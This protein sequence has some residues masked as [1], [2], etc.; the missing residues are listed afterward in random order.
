MTKAAGGLKANPSSLKV[1]SVTYM[2]TFICQYLILTVDRSS[3][4]FS[5]SADCV[6]VIANPGTFVVKPR[7]GSTQPCGVYIAGLHNETITVDFGLVDV[8]CDDDGVVA[9]RILLAMLDHELCT[10]V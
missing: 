5:F 7:S 2:A 10:Y 6:Q 3:L 9:V 4:E 1:V 8:T